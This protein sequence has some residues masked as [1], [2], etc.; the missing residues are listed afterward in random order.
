LTAEQREFT[1]TIQS[2]ADALLTIINDILDFSKVGAGKLT[3]ET[4]D[5]DLGHVAEGAV[6]LLA[7][8]ASAKD[9][10]LGL[11]IDPRVPLALRGDPGRLRQILTNLVSNAVK[12]TERGEVIVRVLLAEETE[13]SALLRFEVRDT[14]IGVPEG[15]QSRLFDAFTQADGSTT[16]KYGGT[17]LGLAI[18]RRL[19]QLMGGDIG[20]QS[21]E[22]HGAT[23]WF[24]TLL[25]KQTD[26]TRGPV[27]DRGALAGRR[28]LVVDDNK[29]NRTILHHQLIACGMDDHAVSGAPQALDALRR[30]AAEKCPFDLAILDRQMPGVDGIMLASA[31]KWDAAIAG[32]P[33]I[34]MTSLGHHDAEEL[35][36]VGILM[37]LTKPVK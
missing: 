27:V 35:R 11:D 6:D 10:E 8:R 5:F 9:I 33:L 32:V 30:A 34:M 21:I 22:G 7:E 37:R 25:E 28:V 13:T 1:E 14:G 26:A 17:G 15:V 23:F 2:S 19:V 20:V 3:F 29:A 36:E 4:L 31:I 18:S 16:R 24:T 12:F